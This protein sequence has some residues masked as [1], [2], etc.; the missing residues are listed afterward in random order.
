MEE[1]DP[2]NCYNDKKSI[3]PLYEYK[4]KRFLAESAMG[5]T[6]ETPWQGVYDATSGIIIAKRDGD[7]LCFHIYDF[8]FF[9]DYLIN[10]TVLSNHQ[11]EK[12]PKNQEPQEHRKEQ[13]SITTD[14]FMNKAENCF[15]R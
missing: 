4:L 10:N 13:G 12:I 14:G 9:R 2:M 15:S 1:I 7:I 6:S 5:M 8:N 11:Q 3:Q